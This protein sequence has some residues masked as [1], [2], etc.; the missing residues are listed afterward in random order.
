MALFNAFIPTSMPEEISYLQHSFGCFSSE[1]SITCC[2]GTLHASFPLIIISQ[3]FWTW[4]PL[5]KLRYLPILFCL[6]ISEVGGTDSIFHVTTCKE[7][8]IFFLKRERSFR[9]VWL[10]GGVWRRGWERKY[11]TLSL[12]ASF[13]LHTGPWAVPNPLVPYPCLCKQLLGEKQLGDMI[14]SRKMAHRGKITLPPHGHFSAWNH[15]LL[16]LILILKEWS[17]GLVTHITWSLPSMPYIGK[18]VANSSKTCS[19]G[20]FGHEC[21]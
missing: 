2:P 4:A 5:L 21:K 14:L 12:P 15:A 18:R 20:S 16:K 17:M 6:L 3:T 10:N 7:I 1:Q 8:P 11:L 19:Q 9:R 13:W